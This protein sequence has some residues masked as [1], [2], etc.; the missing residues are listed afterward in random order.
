[1]TIDG[2]ERHDEPGEQSEEVLG[3]VNFIR[4]QRARSASLIRNMRNWWILRVIRFGAFW[5]FVLALFNIHGAVRFGGQPG[6]IIKSTTVLELAPVV[7][8]ACWAIIAALRG[9]R[10]PRQWTS[11][12]SLHSIADSRSTSTKEAPPR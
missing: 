3:T 8:L 6:T 10:V 7:F 5:A 9:P 12:W 1:M 11:R 2:T 4:E